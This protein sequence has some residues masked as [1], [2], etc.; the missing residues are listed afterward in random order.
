MVVH[1]SLD[2][3]RLNGAHAFFTWREVLQ[4]PGAGIIDEEA[5]SLCDNPDIAVMV[6]G[7][8]DGVGIGLVDEV[9]L[10]YGEVVD[11]IMVQVEIMEQP[12][13]VIHVVVP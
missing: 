2:I 5:V 11:G 4:L 10:Q 1:D 6:G 8:L 7:D 13:V 9:C 3:I 12:A